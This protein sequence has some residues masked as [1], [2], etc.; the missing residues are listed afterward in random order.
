MGFTY[1][2]NLW[3]S[4]NTPAFTSDGGGSGAPAPQVSSHMGGSAQ[5]FSMPQSNQQMAPM[6]NAPRAMPVANSSHTMARSMQESGGNPMPP[7][8]ASRGNDQN[9]ELKAL[10]RATMAH[11]YEN[12]Q[13]QHQKKSHIIAS[14]NSLSSKLD[15]LTSFAY[16]IL[17]LCILIVIGLA[18]LSFRSYKGGDKS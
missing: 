15:Y 16:A 12:L 13:Q 2:D 8:H 17:A 3:E 9:E 1:L 10:L 18:F 5:S 14:H 11:L 6:S 7:T 4:E